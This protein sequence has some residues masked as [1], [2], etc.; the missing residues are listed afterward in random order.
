MKLLNAYIY[1]LCGTA[2]RSSWQYEKM[3]QR[4]QPVLQLCNFCGGNRASLVATRKT[5]ELSFRLFVIFSDQ[6]AGSCFQGATLRKL[7][8][9]N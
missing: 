1:F 8:T 9:T 3:S 5:K 4:H 7:F 6:R 2:A